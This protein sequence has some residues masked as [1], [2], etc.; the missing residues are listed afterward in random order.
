MNTLKIALILLLPWQVKADVIH[1]KDNIR[2]TLEVTAQPKIEV[3]TPSSINL[4]SSPKNNGLYAASVP[5]AV[6]LRRQESFRV[7]VT[8][9]LILTRDSGAAQEF[10]PAAIYLVYMVTGIGAAKRE[11]SEM[12]ETFN[13][14]KTTS[15]QSRIDL[16]LNIY[17][18]AP[19][20]QDIAGQYHGQLTLLFE[21][22]S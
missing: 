4:I 13:L 9:P 6:T 21:T 5:I 1:L 18:Q 11:L 17:A 8:Q 2:I 20:G 3:E 12:P 22:N 10:Y 7:S 16:L 15:S 14:A 19:D